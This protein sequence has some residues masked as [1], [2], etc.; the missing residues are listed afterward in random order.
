MR[1]RVFALALAAL[2]IFAGITIAGVK[3][4]RADINGTCIYNAVSSVVSGYPTL[5]ACDL[6]RNIKVNLTSASEVA[7]GSQDANAT[8][9]GSIAVGSYNLGFSGGSWDRLRTVGGINAAFTNK[10]LA[11]GVCD[12]V[13]TTAAACADVL[14]FGDATGSGYA[15]LV[16]GS[17]NMGY[18]GATWDRLRSIATGVLKVTTGG[19]STNLVSATACTQLF[20]G[21]NIVYKVW[22]A[23]TETATLTIYSDSGCTTPVYSKVPPNGT[24]DILEAYLSVA[25]YKMS[26]AP[27]VKDYITTN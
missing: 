12:P 19:S 27:A 13:G 6:S 22:A 1:R 5:P 25:Y 24:P 3:I 16:A 8:T 21:G 7:P 15:G 10:E 11:N 26:A 20:S 4:A 9:W 14:T 23:G 2:P 17:M 18:N